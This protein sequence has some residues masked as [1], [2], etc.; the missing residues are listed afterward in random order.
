[1]PRLKQQVAKDLLIFGSANLTASLAR[2]RLIDEHRLGLSPIALGA[3]TPL[4]KEGM[5]TKLL[6]ARALKT[7]CVLL[8][9]EAAATRR[10]GE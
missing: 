9:Y 2:R 3:G 5:K 6:E 7:G 1:V 8:R 10:D 4:F